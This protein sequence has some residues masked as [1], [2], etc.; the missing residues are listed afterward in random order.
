MSVYMVRGKNGRENTV[1][2]MFVFKNLDDVIRYLD[3]T[4]LRFH[5]GDPWIT[6]STVVKFDFGKPGVRLSKKEI[7]DAQKRLGLRVCR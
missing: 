1:S 3:K 6:F 5:T 2:R 7:N 4:L